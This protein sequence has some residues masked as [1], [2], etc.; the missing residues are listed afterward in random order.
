LTKVKEDLQLL[1]YLKEQGI[2][3]DKLKVMIYESIDKEKEEEVEVQEVE[4]EQ[5]PE[6]VPP[7]PEKP[8]FTLED[9]SKL[10]EEKVKDVLKIKRKVPSKGKE[11]KEEDRDKKPEVVKKNW[12]EVLV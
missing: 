8:S 6:E 2:T 5:E 4:A 7:E 9:V 10:V 1:N 3:L 12:F 11:I